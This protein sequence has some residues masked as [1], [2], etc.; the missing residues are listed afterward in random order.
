MSRNPIIRF[1]LYPFYFL[2]RLFRTLALLILS[3]FMLLTGRPFY[4]L[5]RFFRNLAWLILSPLIFLSGLFRSFFRIFFP[6]KQPYLP[7]HVKEKGRRTL[8]VHIARFRRECR[9]EPT[10]KE[11]V[12]LIVKVSH[13]VIKRRGKGG[14]WERQK[15]R[16]V[17]LN[18]FGI[19]FKMK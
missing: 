17:L 11:L 8:D 2:K 19:Q 14:H 6:Q 9:R 13:I 15:L 10:E 1:I 7:E 12:G 4:A 5:R 18:E 16:K 3:P